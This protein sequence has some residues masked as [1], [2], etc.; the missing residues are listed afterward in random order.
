MTR[1]QNLGITMLVNLGY[2]KTSLLTQ[3]EKSKIEARV[4]NDSLSLIKNI[5][6]Q[7]TRA[8]NDEDREE[9]YQTAT[10]AFLLELRKFEHVDSK[11]FYK[12]STMRV[13][14]E[15]IDEL[16]RRDIYGRNQRTELKQAA[17]IKNQLSHELGREATQAE[18]YAVVGDVVDEISE[19]SADQMEEPDF[20]LFD[21]VSSAH[22]QDE[23]ERSLMME[24][25]SRILHSLPEN[26]QKIVFLMCIE[27]FSTTE[28]A[29]ALNMTTYSVHRKKTQANQIFRMR[30]LGIETE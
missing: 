22:E 25:V 30:L 12:S 28:V 13:R 20:S 11:Q 19:I 24:R 26:M 21:I 17:I 16:R 15:V 27:G 4:V 9:F 2:Q 8:F 18:V 6:N 10:L 5:V 14:G 1:Y 23:C 3:A 7:Y 29:S